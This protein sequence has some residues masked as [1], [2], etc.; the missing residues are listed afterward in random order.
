MKISSLGLSKKT[1]KQ[2]IAPIPVNDFLKPLIEGLKKNIIDVG[3][4]TEPR[5]G[6]RAL[7]QKVA[8]RLDDPYESGWTFL[9][10]DKNSTRGKE[11]INAIEPLAAYRAMDDASSPLVLN[12]IP[13]EFWVEWIT[14]YTLLKKGKQRQPPKYILIIGDPNEIPFEFQSMLS[15]VAFVGRLDFDDIEE[16]KTYSEKVK[17]MEE[18]DKLVEKE[19]TFF[20]TDHEINSSGCY[21]PTHYNQ[22]DI[23]TYLV[24]E[25]SGLEFK[26]NK[27]LKNNATKKDL[28]DNLQ[29][30][31]PCIAYASCWGVNASDEALNVQKQ[32]TGALCCQGDYSKGFNPDLVL[33]AGEI[34]EDPFLEGGLFFQQSSFSYG[35][36]AISSLSHW[37]SDGESLGIKKQLAPTDF[38]APLPKRLVYH[39]RGPLAFIGHLDELLAY[40]YAK[41]ETPGAERRERIEP[42]RAVLNDILNGRPIGYA[43]NQMTM[44]RS[45]LN[46]SIANNINKTIT[47]FLNADTD[48][49]RLRVALPMANLFLMRNEV[50]N[51]MIFGDPAVR[52]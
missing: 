33:T 49:A 24:P 19:V 45:V 6:F 14:K 8:P 51:Y 13:E 20:A 47:A 26:P 29:K 27:L 23:D 17:K 46:T 44:R 36:P 3:K 43:L 52:L 41:N 39:K 1:S 37:V 4:I 48:E 25:I 32:V 34:P 5:A 22:S 38:V 35:S 12:D 30:S 50:K 28:L 10:N 21:D 9:I 40:G 2:S 16:L 18:Q 15:D 42:I 7:A 31:R 11:I